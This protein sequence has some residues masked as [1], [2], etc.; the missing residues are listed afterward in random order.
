ML[1]VCLVSLSVLYFI[2]CGQDPGQVYNFYSYDYLAYAEWG[3]CC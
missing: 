3:T 2:Y 1:V